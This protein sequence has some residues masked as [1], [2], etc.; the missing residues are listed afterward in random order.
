M[1]IAFDYS[2]FSL[3]KYGGISR[4]FVRL[5][6]SLKKKE[7]EV[8]IFAP[9]HIN[10][11]IKEL[12]KTVY[13]GKKITNIPSKMGRF[14]DLF[15]IF[16]SRKLIKDYEA[17]IIHNTYFP[18]YSSLM[19]N[20][21]RVVTVHDMIHEKFKSNFGFWDKT[22]SLKRKAISEADHIVCISNSTKNDL[23][24]L[25]NINEEKISVIHHGYEKSFI[26]SSKEKISN[27]DAPYLLFVGSRNGYKN[28]TNFIKGYASDNELMMNFNVLAFGGNGFNSSELNLFRELKIPTS[29]IKHISGS[30]KE[31]AQLYVNASAFVYPSI[32]EGFGLPLLEA[33]AAECPV[34]AFHS[35][36]IPEVAGNAAEFIYENVPGEISHA[37]KKVVF[38]DSR[39]NQLILAG[40]KQLNNFSWEKC[41]DATISSYKKIL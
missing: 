5:A 9:R 24:D 16:C 17:D 40:R 35:S 34:V 19:S 36:S 4:Y 18:R 26:F 15:N 25:Y 37:I 8:K 12:D 3:Q 11:Y 21:P 30:D 10:N 13:Y 23:L 2:I 32:Y 7:I 1:K 29:K 22:S 31:L 28:F 20:L 27:Q 33:M 39:K 41:A 6:S 38:S 14:Y